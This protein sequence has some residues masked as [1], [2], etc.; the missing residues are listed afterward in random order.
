MH[1]ANTAS[2]HNLVIVFYCYFVREFGARTCP[3]MQVLSN[4]REEGC[5]S[6]QNA[7]RKKTT[8]LS[9]STLSTRALDPGPTE[10]RTPFLRVCVGKQRRRT[11]ARFTASLLCRQ[12]GR[13]QVERDIAS[14]WGIGA[15]HAPL[16]TKAQSQGAFR[17]FGESLTESETAG[18][19][20]HT[21]A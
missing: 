3:H 7:Y 19:G 21:V 4:E 12:M 5:L 18:E 16:Q 8:L 17:G 2:A 10:I 13:G 14:H 1:K 15:R 20:G 11:A 6:S 9:N